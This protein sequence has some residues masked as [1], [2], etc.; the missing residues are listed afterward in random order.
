MYLDYDIGDDSYY[1][2]TCAEL[3]A[4][5]AE[6]LGKDKMERMLKAKSTEDFFA[7][8]RDT[9]YSK[10]ISEIENSG[11]FESFIL[12]EYKE[13]VNYLSERLRPEHQ[14]VKDLLFLELNIHNLKVIVKSV[15]GDMDLEDLF[16]PLFCSY[17]DMKDAAVGENYEAVGKSVFGILKHS[18]EIAKGQKSRRLMELELEQFYLE[19][20]SK[21][22]KSL[23]S[24]MM[25]DYLKHFV[26]ITNIKNICRT[27]YL[28]EDLKFDS[29]LYGNGFLP[30][31]SL[32]VFKDEELE[33]F[34]KE[35]GRTDYADMVTAGTHDLQQKGTFS[36]FEK[37]EDLFYIDFF[38]P[39]N[40]TVSNLEKIFQ[41]FLT[42]KM[43]LGYLNIIFTGVLYGISEERIKSRVGV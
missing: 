39:V 26:D 6:F 42:K 7:V 13:T 5:E 33:A 27:K 36:T 30:M 14:P 8:L 23:K 35:M 28:K 22:V 17:S 4:R 37:K 9:V 24:R 3:R 11:S 21:S 15:T 19:N 34:V 25:T 20:I 41:F 43:G 12:E 32:E 40:Y 38:E 29:F 18:L 31:G 1:L 16:I 2:F 10:H